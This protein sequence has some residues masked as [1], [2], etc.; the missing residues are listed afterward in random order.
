MNNLTKMAA[1]IAVIVAVF[2]CT[3]IASDNSEAASTIYVD[4]N[5]TDDQT[6]NTYSTLAGAIA[7]A[8]DGDI[9]TLKSDIT[10][11]PKIELD[12]GKEFTIDLNSFDIT[13]AQNAYFHVVN[14][15]LVITGNGTVKEGSPYYGPFLINTPIDAVKGQEYV[16]LTVGENVTVEGWAPIFIDFNDESVVKN[17]YG[18]TIDVYGT[19]NS[20][21]DYTGAAGHGIYLNGTITATDDYATINVHEGATITSNGNG[22]YIAGYA[23]LNVYGGNISGDTGIEIRAG[24]LNIKG[25]TITATGTEFNSAPNGNGSTTSGVAIVVSQHTTDLPIDVSISG[26]SMSGLYALYQATTDA[27]NKPE[28]IKIDIKGGNFSTT[29]TTGEYGSV[30]A[31]DSRNFVSGGSYNTD[32]SAYLADELVAVQYA[33]SGMFLIQNQDAFFSVDIVSDTENPFMGEEVNLTAVVTGAPSGADLTYK[34]YVDEKAVEGNGDT[35][36]VNAGRVTYNVEVYAD[37]VYLGQTYAEPFTFMLRIDYTLDGALIDSQT[38]LQGSLPELPDLPELPTGYEYQVDGIPVID[39]TPFELYE[40]WTVPITTG[41]ADV[42]ISVTAGID[43]AGN[44]ML[45][46]SVSAPVNYVDGLC[47]WSLDNE[48]VEA[49]GWTMPLTVSGWYYV[50]AYVEDADGHFGFD[51]MAFYFEVPDDGETDISG[52]G[53]VVNTSTATNT[54]IITTGTGANDATLNLAYTDENDNKV[55][56]IAITG[57]VGQGVAAVTVNPMG[58][59]TAKNAV[60]NVVSE[61]QASKAVGVDVK[62][63][64][65]TDYRMTI[66]VPMT[67]DEGQYAG[68][69]VAY[70]IEE[71]GSLTP[72]DCIVRGTEVWIYTTHNT[73]YVAVPTSIVSAPVE[74]EEP[75]FED[76]DSGSDLPPFI[77][78]P[79]QDDGDPIEVYPSQDGGS[80]SG[81]DDTMKVVAVAAAAVIAAILAIIL[82]STYRKN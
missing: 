33:D 74:Q 39:W 51:Y 15:S 42:S 25:G 19:L 21:N 76:D 37:G 7:A 65:V 1:V 9:I 54:A 22:A 73:E 5:A 38:V 55:A 17:A 18:V 57:N 29:D 80:S 28:L 75:V 30:W 10:N 45:T 77:P 32:P 34:W 78:F 4:T 81:R 53:G 82:A 68:S 14:A 44:P 62:V 26:G 60:S 16:S 31:E 27:G 8:T 12:N 2:G 61:E 6:T 49:T 11:C 46:A 66:K 67:L 79:P 23:A 24:I 70:F 43:S 71:D 63:S 48:E 59:N 52:S 13:F 50:A 56:D 41:I 69:A 72:V 47:I 40:D 36:T 58:S 3:A 20:V 64:N 35:I